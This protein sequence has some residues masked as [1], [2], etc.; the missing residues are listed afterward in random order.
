M[1]IYIFVYSINKY[2]VSI[3]YVL[4]MVPGIE[5]T[6]VNNIDKI[7]VLVELTHFT[8]EDWQKYI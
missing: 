5:N 8:G 2:L 7:K 3:H 4:G 1:F 6:L